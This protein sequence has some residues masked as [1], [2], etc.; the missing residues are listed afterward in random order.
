MIGLEDLFFAVQKEYDLTT[1]DIIR[2]ETQQ[3]FYLH[4]SQFSGEI[5]GAY[6]GLSKDVQSWCQA[7]SKAYL[8]SL[9]DVKDQVEAVQKIKQIF[10]DLDAEVGEYSRNQVMSDLLN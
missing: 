9:H 2:M 7:E 1:P 5:R 8:K 10:V 3:Q 4:S 6:A